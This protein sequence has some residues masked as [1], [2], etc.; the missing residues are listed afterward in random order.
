MFP[1]VCNLSIFT[2]WSNVVLEDGRA[3]AGEMESNICV[4]SLRVFSLY[5]CLFEVRQLL[6]KGIWSYFRN[7]WNYVEFMPLVLILVNVERSQWQGYLDLDFFRVQALAALLMWGKFLYFLRSFENTGYLI[8]S[9][10][11]VTKDMWVFL[12]VLAVAILGYADA[13]FSTSNSL[14]YDDDHEPF[15]EGGFAD[16]LAFSYNLMLGDWDTG[17]FDW[18]SWVLFI[19]ASMLEMIIMLNLLIAIISATFERVTAEQI[20]YTYSERV[21]L[22]ADM[23]SLAG[24]VY[25]SKKDDCNLLFIAHEDPENDDAIP[26]EID[27]EPET[28]FEAL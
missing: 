17:N 12:I 18:F 8:R 4:W 24:N 1:Y 2:Y 19:T 16:A 28:V 21:S 26:D 9:L 11:E 3:H 22:I 5:F 7:P 20:A 10:I 23:Y 6:T 15:I 27:D 25:G 13:F 14:L